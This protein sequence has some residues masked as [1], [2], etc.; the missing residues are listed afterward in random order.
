M[1]RAHVK[2]RDV[3]TPPVS[4]LHV[5]LHG[6]HNF[7]RLETDSAPPRRPHSKVDDANVDRV[8]TSCT[9]IDDVDHV[10]T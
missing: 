6:D 5:F 7:T 3:R 2:Q 4:P 9:G 10:D 8:Q 1:S